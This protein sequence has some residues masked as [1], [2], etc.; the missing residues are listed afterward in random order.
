MSLYEEKHALYRKYVE[1]LDKFRKKPLRLSEKECRQI[2]D[3]YIQSK[4]SSWHNIYDPA[5][6]NLVGFVIIG[7][8]Y[9]EKHRDSLRSVSQAYVLPQYRKKGLM[10]EVMSDYLTRPRHKGV[11]SLLVLEGNR[12]AAGFWRRFFRKEG[13]VETTLWPEG[14]GDREAGMYAWMPTG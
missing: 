8:N 12:Y 11:Y 1:E 9:P 7:K 6:G 13:Y 14:V 5:T 2:C 3:D 10:S 4:N